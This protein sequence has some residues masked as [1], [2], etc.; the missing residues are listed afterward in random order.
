MKNFIKLNQSK[1][2]SEVKVGTSLNTVD[3]EQ[4]IYA[5]MII[6]IPILVFVSIVYSII[7]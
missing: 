6:G 2:L 3:Q 7:K 4:K 5:G 1:V